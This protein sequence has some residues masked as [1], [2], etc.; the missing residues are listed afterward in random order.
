MRAVTAWWVMV[1]LVLVWGCGRG[2]TQPDLRQGPRRIPE[3]NIV[4]PTGPPMNIVGDDTILPVLFGLSG[5][6]TDRVEVLVGQRV[7][8][9][10]RLS[11]ALPW[12]RMSEPHF[13]VYIPSDRLERG[14][15]RRLVFRVYDL[16]GKTYRDYGMVYHYDDA[17]LQREAMQFLCGE[18]FPWYV[19]P[20]HR[21]SRFSSR[22]IYVYIDMRRREVSEAE[23]RQVVWRALREYME[24]WTGLRFVETDTIHVR[25]LLIIRDDYLGAGGCSRKGYPVQN[26]N[27][28]NP[29]EVWCAVSGVGSPA[30]FNAV[31][32]EIGHK[33]PLPHTPCAFQDIMNDQG[34][35]LRL[36]NPFEQR[37][38]KLLYQYPPGHRFR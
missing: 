32:H 8:A 24:P 21:W 14:R 23:F 28:Q 10:V 3:L 2:P 5:R 1:L 31:L 9:T 13:Y 38:V 25:P 4:H 12:T 22:R 27:P 35:D 19:P 30:S 34:C 29:Y 15:N 36:L 26:V 16:V 20:C 6:S 7:V 33:I 37:F 17:W 18:G 11:D